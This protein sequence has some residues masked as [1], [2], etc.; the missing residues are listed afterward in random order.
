MTEGDMSAWKKVLEEP[1]AAG[2]IAFL[3]LMLVIGL[4]ILYFGAGDE[5]R[6]ERPAPASQAAR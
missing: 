4:V 1:N 5:K 6:A 3:V 2:W